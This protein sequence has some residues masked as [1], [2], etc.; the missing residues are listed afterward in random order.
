MGEG[1]AVAGERGHAAFGVVN[2]PEPPPLT[3]SDKMLDRDC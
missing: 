1:P 3:R 2:N